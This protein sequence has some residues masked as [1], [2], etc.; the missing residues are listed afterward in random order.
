MDQMHQS[1]DVDWLGGGNI[2]PINMLSARDQLQIY[3]HLRSESKRIGKCTP[4]KWKSRF[5]H[6]G[7]LHPI[8]FSFTIKEA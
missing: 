5:R 3:G 6:Y 1:R 8:I 7:I 4:C 2:R